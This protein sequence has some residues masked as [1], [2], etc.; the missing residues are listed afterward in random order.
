MFVFISTVAGIFSLFSLF[1]VVYNDTTDYTYASYIVKMWVW[2]SGAYAV[3]SLIRQVHGEVSI[4]Q[5]FHYM[6][7]V[8]AVQALLGIVIDSVPVIQGW[9]DTYIAQ[10]TELF[11]KTKRLY[12]IGAGFDTA[13]IRFS[14]ALLGLGYLLTH[15]VSDKQTMWYWGLFFTIGI[16]GNI[17]SRT[18]TVGL[19]L[20]LLYMAFTHFSLNIQLD[21]SKMKSFIHSILLAG[22][23]AGITYYCYH[24]FPVFR[25]NLQYGFEGF[26]NWY[27]TGD[28]NTSS[29]SRL[30]KMFI[31]PDNLK[32]WLIGDGWF[33]NPDEP[34]GFYKYTDIGYLRFIFYCGCIGLSLFV[35]FFICCTVILFRKWKEDRFF[36]L[37]LFLLKLIVWVKIST[38]IFLVY[39]LL[40]L[41]D[42]PVPVQDNVYSPKTTI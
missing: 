27:E 20:A 1:S 17:M 28:W 42:R 30:Q 23:V 24:H 9:V 14:C 25:N 31:L 6:A 11:H 22:V 38:D 8:C 3:L 12:G 26:V 18:T 19:V 2:L 36:L 35:S 34:G 40:L 39:A 33:D 10:N 21:S 16:L 13:G 7:C 5:V 15:R 37:L 41:L 32:T 29:T 4:R